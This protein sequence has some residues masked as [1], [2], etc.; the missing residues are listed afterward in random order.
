[1]RLVT[2]DD[3]VPGVLRGEEV[4]DLTPAIGP[5]ARL[6]WDERIP[7]LIGDYGQ[8]RPAVEDVAAHGAGIPLSGVRL[9]A[10]NPRPGKLLC[11][12]GSFKQAAEGQPIVPDFFFKSPESVI[13]PGDTVV[14][15]AIEASMYQAEAC[16][17]LV[18]GREARNVSGEEGLSC[19]F[20]YTAFID[21]FGR[22]V[23]RPVGTYWAKS[24]DTFAPMGPCIVTAD[25][26]G[27]PHGL[28]V[29]LSVNGQLRQDYLTS[30][31]VHRVSAHVAT[32]TAIMTMYPGDMIGC[33]SDQ[34]G[35]GPLSDGDEAVAE[36]TDIGSLRVRVDDSLRRTWPREVRP[37][38][39]GFSGR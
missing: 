24:F 9:R 32:A 15:P 21:V 33:A 11:A 27:D 25:E 17:A 35:L 39:T 19:V 3:F 20:G 30:G 14:L 13:G 37:A 28:H 26:L 16:L 10:P 4:V 29:R 6:P 8:L 23:G 5:I 36:V 38:G 18:V 31:M 1:M 22:D 7:A 12:V 2:F 34:Q